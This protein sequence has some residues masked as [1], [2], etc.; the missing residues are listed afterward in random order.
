MQQH[1]CAEAL[2]LLDHLVGADKDRAAHRD[3][4][5]LRSFHI[6]HQF[7]LGRLLDR[8]IGRLGALQNLVYENSGPSVHFIFCA[9]ISREPAIAR[10]LSPGA[11]GGYPVAERQVRGSV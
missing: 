10:K 3:T 7:K 2:D 11:N 4:E 9:E 8:K 5:R 1:E 6:D